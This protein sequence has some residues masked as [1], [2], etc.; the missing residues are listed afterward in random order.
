MSNTITAFFKGRVGVCESLYQYDYGIVLTFD[1]IELPESFECYFETTESDEAIPAIGTDRRVAIPNDC[2]T[3]AGDV[4]LHIPLHEGS[5]DSEVEYLVKFRVIGRARPVDDGTPEQ[6]TAIGQALALLQ[7]PI[8][9]IEQIVNEA[10]SFTGDTF[11]EMQNK[12]DQDQAEFE[13]DI[14]TRQSGFESGISSRQATV[15]S[16]VTNLVTSTRPTEITNLWTGTISTKNATASLS[17]SIANFDFIDVYISGSTDLYQR[18]AVT[19]S[20]TFEIQ[21]QN[22]DDAGTEQF[23]RMWEKT[24]TLSGKNA[25]ITKSVQ[26]YWDNFS[27][28]PV[29]SNNST[30]GPD[31]VRIDGVKLLKDN[32]PEL[33]DTRVGADNITYPSAGEAVRKQFTDLKS[34]IGDITD[35]FDVVQSSNHF[36]ANNVSEGKTI[37][38][39]GTVRDTP[40]YNV[41]DFIEV[42]AGDVLRSF[43]KTT[44]VYAANMAKIA[45][46]NSAKAIMASQGSDT[47]VNT[48]TIPSGV[49]FVRITVNDALMPTFMLTIN[50]ST[51]PSDY[52]PFFKNYIAT[53]AFVEK[54]VEDLGVATLPISKKETDFWHLEKSANLFDKSQVIEGEYFNTNGLVGTTNNVFRAYVEIDGSGVYSLKVMGNFYG[55]ANAVK[56]PVFDKNKNYLKT[57]TGST[58]ETTATNANLMSINI[59]TQDIEDGVVYLG[60]SENPMNL[61]SLVIVKAST[62]PSDYIPYREE[63]S[64]P[65]LSINAD[66]NPLYGKIAVFDGDSICAGLGSAMGDYENGWAGRIGVDNNMEYYNV[67]VSGACVTAETYFSGGGARHWVSRYIDTIYANH[68]DADYVIGEGG[69]NDADNFYNDPSKL[70]TFSESDFTGPFDDTTFYG[71]MDSWCK[72]ALTYFPKAKVGFIV[73]HKMG[74]GFVTYVK[75]RYDYFTYAEKV[76]KKW[77]IPVLN[78]WDEG[79]LRPDVLSMYNPSYNTIESATE[80]GLPYYD[81]QHLT[82]YG[83]DA[84]S[85]KIEAWM[86]TL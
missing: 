40:G 63:W 12:L 60:Y 29:V 17:E 34:D 45:C 36:D 74:T 58:A 13:T 70:G 86:K 18:K 46:Y 56:L 80:Q 7:N 51:T 16:Q 79:Q 76:C 20:M 19:N 26:F 30:T 22:L 66:S 31:V 78:L 3:R 24:L 54:A 85:P 15:E 14:S 37:D 43:Y 65:D 49:S 75:N 4:T 23:M 9:N 5:S 32:I 67:G 38:A 77:G 59:S 81:G 47:A 10:L 44:S 83:Y 53:T 11:E 33:T 35:S 84:I 61:D 69:T 71:A 28:V 73:A 48:F 62:Y 68:P 57:I 64:L 27:A 39:D 6:E 72:K 8:T 52:V 41:T 2:L 82:A 25:T 42:N 55:L 1:G 50:D 21:C